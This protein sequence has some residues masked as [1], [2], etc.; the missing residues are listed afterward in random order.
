MGVIWNS[1][2]ISYILDTL[3]LDFYC[4]DLTQIEK[5]LVKNLK[6]AFWYFLHRFLPILED[7][8]WL[9]TLIMGLIWNPEKIFYMVDTMF[10]DFYCIYL[11]KIE[12][13]CVGT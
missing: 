9:Q 12:K 13:H 11:I 7:F 10:L 2:E 4:I 3:F 5:Y 6:L 8:W 1:E